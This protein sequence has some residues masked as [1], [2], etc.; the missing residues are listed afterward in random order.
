MTV[1]Q[2]GAQQLDFLR[3]IVGLLYTRKHGPSGTL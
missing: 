2:A 1:W 3:D